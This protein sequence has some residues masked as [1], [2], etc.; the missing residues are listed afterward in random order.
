MIFVVRRFLNLLLFLSQ[1]SPIAPIWVIKAFF[2]DWFASKWSFSRL[3]EIGAKIGLRH[4]KSEYLKEFGELHGRI[5]GHEVFVQ[6]GQHTNP[7][8]RVKYINIY[9]GLNLSLINN[10][11][12][13]DKNVIDFQ[14][15]D[16]K[17]NWTFKTKRAHKNMVSKISENHELID[18]ITSFYT[19]WIF[20]F[21]ELIIGDRDIYC[22]F[23]YGFNFFPYIPASKL[24]P[25]IN[26]LLALTEKI[27]SALEKID[28]VLDKKEKEG[29]GM[30]F[31][32][33]EKILDI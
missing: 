30:Q 4:K 26:E 3:P 9:K 8:V 24:E 1:F 25:L 16:W 31:I 5:N 22:C 12:R 27:D 18:L 14:T 32:P 29:N 21:D 10:I 20:T 13:P 17:F 7:V 11:F 15:S 28:S 19:K 23:R 2:I 6:L 33:I